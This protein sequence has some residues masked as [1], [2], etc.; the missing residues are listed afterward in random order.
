MVPI[1]FPHANAEKIMMEI[2]DFY[3]SVQPAAREKLLKVIV[4]MRPK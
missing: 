3:N 4:L 1:E 2:H